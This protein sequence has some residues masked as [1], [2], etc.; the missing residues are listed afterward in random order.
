MPREHA[1][2]AACDGDLGSLLGPNEVMVARDVVTVQEQE[3]LVDWAEVQFHRGHLFQ[4]PAD[5][6][7][8]LTHYQS[9]DGGLTRYTQAGRKQAD[10]TGQKFVYVPPVDDSARDPLPDIFW[11]VEDRVRQVLD[12][13]SLEEDPYKGSFL[14]Y[15]VP[16]GSVHRHCDA[17]VTIDGE[18][19]DIL[20]CNV[21]FRRPGDGGQPVIRS[22]H[23]DVPDRGMWAF[24]PTAL[25]HAATEVSHGA[26]RGTLSFGFLVPSRHLHRRS[27]RLASA[28]RT[29]YGLDDTQDRREALITQLRAARDAASLDAQRLA[30]FAYAIR[31]SHDFTVGEAARELG[32]SEACSN[33]ELINLQRCGLLESASSTRA[34]AAVTVL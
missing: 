26:W 34:G 24:F 6:G 31:A 14:T 17:K 32:V 12:A 22:A 20:R 13:V 10:E 11:R 4:S 27:F 2:L 16:G 3:A 18:A 33:E 19:C 15:T 7:V 5:P 9:A 8:Y 25:V 29:Q 1:A 21:L 30:H 28:V 23:F